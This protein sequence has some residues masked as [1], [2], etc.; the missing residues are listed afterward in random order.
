MY[1][2]GLVINPFAGIGGRVG[3]KGSDGELT[4]QQALTRGALKL[5]SE[6]VEIT[7]GELVEC[8]DKFQ[9]YTVSGEMGESLCIKL[10]LPHKVIMQVKQPSQADDTRAAVIKLSEYPLDLVLFAG[11]DGTARDVYQV[12]NP[13]QT[14]LGIPAGV[15][16]HSG[17]YANTPHAAGL[18][19]K[20]MLGGQMLSL[21]SADV[22]DIDEDAFRKG[23]VKA[24]K[25]GYL[26]VPAALEYVQAVKSGGQE[27][28]TLVLQDIAAEVIENMQQDIYYVI[29]SGSSCSAIMQQLGLP[30]TLLGSD[31]LFNQ[32]LHKADAVE[33]D[34]LELLAKG[35]KLH[36]VIT[37]IGGQG[38]ILGRGNQQISPAVIR[39]TGWENF[40][41]IA[42]KT[43]LQQ[44]NGKALIVDSGDRA[45]DMQLA[46]SIVIITGYRDRVLYAVG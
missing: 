18:L 34:F 7:L 8:K 10:G 9:I 6:R 35:N 33:K 17:V 2:L 30:N 26:N 37:I 36:F 21:L 38:H 15:K 1:K 29:G 24:K 41:V 32:Q 42:T 19:V 12:G 43:K 13:Q 40:S 3:L 20:Q 4:R 46:G 5:A 27:S 22:M 25:F 39:Q 16:I 31:I 44:L 14:F 45:L 11:G 23:I 28:G